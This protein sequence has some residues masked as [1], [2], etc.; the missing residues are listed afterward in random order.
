MAKKNQSCVESTNI[1]R[2]YALKHG[3]DPSKSSGIR[4]LQEALCEEGCDVAPIT[5]QRW[6][7]GESFP[8]P[9]NLEALC[10]VLDLDYFYITGVCLK[11]NREYEEKIDI[12]QIPSSCFVAAKAAKEREELLRW[13]PK[14][15]WIQ[16]LVG[17][18]Y[19]SRGDKEVQSVDSAIYSTL[20]GAAEYGEF[21]DEVCFRPVL[22]FMAKRY[23]INRRCRFKKSST[24]VKDRPEDK[25]YGMFGYL[26]SCVSVAHDYSGLSEN[27]TEALSKIDS[28]IALWDGG[29]G[30]DKEEMLALNTWSIMDCLLILYSRCSDFFGYWRCYCYIL[31]MMQDSLIS[32]GDEDERTALYD[33][34][35]YMDRKAAENAEKEVRYG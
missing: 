8:D 11:V 13:I 28:L 32:F 25:R 16:S 18:L 5:I 34:L 26:D 2:S 14:N 33:V 6:F 20:L 22:E 24:F 10:N 29:R 7:R 35:M 30:K 9:D 31:L 15:S 23:G 17:N 4:A 21:V 27:E 12:K 3:F 19:Q 1:L